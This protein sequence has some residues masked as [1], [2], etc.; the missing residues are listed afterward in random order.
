MARAVLCGS[1]NLEATEIVFRSVASIAGDAVTRIPDGEP[2]ER[3]LWI[4]HQIPRLAALPEL[5]MVED[6]KVYGDKVKLRLRSGANPAGL[7][8]DLGYADAAAESYDTFGA[9]KREGVIA[10]STRFQVSLPTPMALAAS[11][12]T[13]DQVP[14]VLPRI[15]HAML[16]E[17]TRITTTV[18][19][20]DLA[21][22]WDVAA[23]IALIENLAPNPFARNPAPL[24][25]HVSHLGDAVPETAELGFHLCYGDAVAEDGLGH[26]FMEPVD[27]R[28]L[29]MV[30]NGIADRVRR[31]IAWIQMPVPIGRDDDA[32][33]ASLDHLRLPPSTKLHLG[34]L[35]H[36]DGLEGANRRVRAAAR[37]VQGFG[38]ATE[39]G[40]GRVPR[41][42][43][44]DLLRL[45]ALVEIPEDDHQGAASR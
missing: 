30:A 33:F 14:V 42:D 4:H 10:P 44:P 15:E 41:E 26:H 16:D 39:C 36:E 9:L 29:V 32:Y 11:Y 3:S 31:P 8:F 5:E 21:I 12:F 13:Q 18:S 35:H 40:M 17:L 6:V 7:R 19:P 25:D 1:V 24:L 2:G 27:T 37:H 45:H 38:I 20:D 28:T 22:Q 43:I 23:E 34:L